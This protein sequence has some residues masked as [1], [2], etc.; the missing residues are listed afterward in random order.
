MLDGDRT[1]LRCRG[2]RRAV[3]ELRRLQAAGF[4]PLLFELPEQQVR[5]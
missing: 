4:A 1:K 2:R 5:P 3:A